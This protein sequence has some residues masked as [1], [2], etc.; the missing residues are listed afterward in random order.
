MLG[1]SLLR[2]W[3]ILLNMALCRLMESLAWGRVTEEGQLLLPRLRRAESSS[4]SRPLTHR[5]WISV[6]YLKMVLFLIT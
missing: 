1:W 5:T 2:F 6:Q 4:A 3:K